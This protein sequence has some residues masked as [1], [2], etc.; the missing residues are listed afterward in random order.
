MAMSSSA[1]NLLARRTARANM[2][3]LADVR[4]AARRIR[5]KALKTSS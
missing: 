3:A 2:D 1:P 5:R 4:L